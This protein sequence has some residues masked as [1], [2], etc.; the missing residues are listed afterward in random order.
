[1]ANP[2]LLPLAVLLA[3]PGIPGLPSFRKHTVAPLDSLPPAWRS[4][5]QLGLESSFVRAW[6][7]RLGPTPGLQIAQDPRRAKV[8]FDADSGRVRYSTEMG[9]VVLG[10]SVSV[11]INEFGRDLSNRNFERLWRENSRSTIGLKGGTEIGATGTGTGLSFRFPS[12]LPRKMQ[13]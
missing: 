10:Q 8:A 4:A 6:L 3:F 12:P 13:S 11:P 2:L 7:P 1:M 9:N 5:S